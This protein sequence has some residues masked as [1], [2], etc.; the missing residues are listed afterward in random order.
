MKKLITIGEALIDFIPLE[1]GERLKDVP[2]FQR[3]VGGAPANVA[4]AVAK[5]G[6]KSV[7][8]TQL[9][10]DAFGHHIIDVLNENHID[11]QYIKLSSN[12]DTSLAFV[13]LANDGNRDFKFYRK[14]A[15]DLQFAPSDI[16]VNIL[17]DTG[18]IHFCSV[19]LVESPMRDAHETLI[20]MAKASNVLVSFDPNLR[21]SLWNDL[22]Q[23]Q[24][25]VQYFLQ[26]SDIVKISDDE[27]EFITGETEIEKALPIL[28]GY[29][30]RLIIY[31]RGGN[32]AMIYYHD[33]FVEVAGHCVEVKD[34]TGGGDSFIGAFLYCLLSDAN[35]DI[36]HLSKSVLLN[37]LRFANDYAA[38]TVTQFGAL[39]AMADFNT[40][41]MFRKQF[42]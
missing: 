31:T 2:L 18:V 21:F 39:T 4:G 14:T 13:S 37:Y 8:L 33:D 38:Y 19:D 3:V 41:L 42:N 1:K 12:Y 10:D 11:T 5:L 27:L 26:F 6:G 25:T 36:N 29:G 7:L 34:T 30:C 35:F 22:T 28:F 40:F 20:T 17:E 32:G 24:K 9:G 23:L 15:A 16:P